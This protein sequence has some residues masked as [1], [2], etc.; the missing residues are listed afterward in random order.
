MKAIITNLIV[1]L[2]LGGIT[3]FIYPHITG[4]ERVSSKIYSANTDL[5]EATGS[6]K[7][8]NENSTVG[9]KIGNMW[10]MNVKGTMGGLK[11]KIVIS[12]N[13]SESSVELLIKPETINT[14]TKKRDD[15]L[16]NEEFFDVEKYSSIVFKGSTISEVNKAFRYVVKGKLTIKDVTKEIE[17]PFNYDGIS[18][19]DGTKVAKFSGEVVI[20][21]RDFHLD[22]FSGM[23]MDDDAIVNFVIEAR[24]I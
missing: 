13:I 4:N 7:I 10:F 24:K 22:D 23:G 2:L 8:D 14:G 3:S 15:H 19:K 17:V 16:R 1:A 18:E 12:K 9:F 5:S 11:G 6:W 20:D 21:R